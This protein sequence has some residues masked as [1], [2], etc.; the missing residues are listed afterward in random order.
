MES[1]SGKLFKINDL[2]SMNSD[3]IESN[4]KKKNYFI[5]VGVVAIGVF[6]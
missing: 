3:K 2:G 6:F 4:G 5:I 1:E